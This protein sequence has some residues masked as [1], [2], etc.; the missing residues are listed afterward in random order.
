MFCGSPSQLTPA[1]LSYV[2]SREFNQPSEDREQ[3]DDDTDDENDEDES[4][5][6]SDI[7]VRHII[8]KFRFV[9]KPLTAT[10]EDIS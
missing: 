8:I 9:E 1:D 4:E 5:A 3:Y 2:T 6:E 7:S 10:N